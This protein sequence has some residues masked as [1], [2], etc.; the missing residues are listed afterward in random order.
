MNVDQ[1]K[2][3]NIHDFYLDFEIMSN[4]LSSLKSKMPSGLIIPIFENDIRS[5]GLIKI[6]HEINQCDY[7]SKV[8]IALSAK[9]ASDYEEALRLSRSFKVPCEVVWCNKPEVITVLEEL[10]RKGLDVTQMSGKGKDVWMTIGIASLELFAFAVHDADIVSYTKMLPTKMLYPI[11]E[12]K[13]DFF[14]CK[15]YYARINADNK[16]L[17]GRIHRLF[18]NPLLEVLQEKLRYSRF[19]TYLQS[20]SYPL[21]GEISVY[22]DLATHLRVPCDWGL[23]LGLLSEVYRN[24]SYGRVCQI[25][26][27]FYD[28]RHKK[29]EADSLLKTAEDSFITLLRTLTET[30]NIDVSEPFLTSLQVAYQAAGSR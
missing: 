30:E 23:E 26:L 2:I 13:L 21:A 6:V 8:F 15:G 20:F 3:A 12:P 19:L 5:P 10:K 22:S 7:L 24:A 14:F 4:Q 29:I 27:G 11:I 18:I 9:T 25:D 1:R 28:H 16:K 17:Y